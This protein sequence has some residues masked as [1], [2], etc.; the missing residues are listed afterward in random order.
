MSLFIVL[1]AY[2]EAEDLPLLLERIIQSKSAQDHCTLIVIDD[3]STDET[4]SVAESFKNR[5]EIIVARHSKNLGL[6]AAFRTGLTKALSIAGGDD[7]I[8]SMDAD[9][10]HSPELIPEM[11]KKIQEGTDVVIASRYAPGGAEVGVAEHRKFLSAG[12][13]GILK[14]FFPIENVNDYT[15]GYRMMRV[16]ILKR[17]GEQTGQLFFKEEGFVCMSELLL[18]LKR[19]AAKF[20]EVPLQLRYDLKRGASKMKIFRTIFSYLRLIFR[21]RFSSR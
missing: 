15:C 1:P 10:S 16:S 8:V 6:G 13:S 5:L 21:Y 11:K 14:L 20:C 2:N 17:C 19:C 9:N 12:C 7:L 18:N 4:V 3:G